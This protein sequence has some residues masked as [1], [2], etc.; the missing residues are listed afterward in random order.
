MASFLFLDFRCEIYTRHGYKER[1]I[2]FTV[3]R[4]SIESLKID[5]RRS[6]YELRT[7]KHNARMINKFARINAEVNSLVV[8]GKKRFGK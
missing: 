3:F 6:N 7:V 4:F 2:F 1:R 5:L 8:Y